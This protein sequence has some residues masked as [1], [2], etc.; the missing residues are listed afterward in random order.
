[1]YIGGIMIIQYFTN[2]LRVS[3]IEFSGTVFTLFIL[4]QLF[5]AFNSRELTSNSI[6]SSIGKNKIMVLTFL[7]VFLLHVFIVEVFYSAFSVRP[8]SFLTWI[9]ALILSSSIVIVSEIYKLIYR[10]YQS[11][12]KKERKKAKIEN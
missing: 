12:R 2:F 7:A 3:P 6:F 5:N 8:L 10:I 4:F 9:K 11:I 1:M